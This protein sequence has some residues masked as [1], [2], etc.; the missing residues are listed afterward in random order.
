[1]FSCLQADFESDMDEGE[2][3]DREAL[4]DQSEPQDEGISEGPPVTIY[5]LLLVLN[6]YNLTINNKMFNVQ[7]LIQ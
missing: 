1:M 2:M 7:N 4:N 5:L 3:K 6:G